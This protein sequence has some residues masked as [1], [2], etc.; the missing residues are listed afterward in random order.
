MTWQPIETAQNGDRVWVA[1]WHKKHGTVAG[2]WWYHEDVI[3]NGK[4]CE[5]PDATIWCPIELPAFPPPP[6]GDA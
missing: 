2:Y 1:G 4:P 5:H 3:F 6:A